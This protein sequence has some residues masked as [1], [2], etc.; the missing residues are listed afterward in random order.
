MKHVS[1]GTSNYINIYN[2]LQM[3]KKNSQLKDE[4]NQT[5]VSFQKTFYESQTIHFETLKSFEFKIDQQKGP[6]DSMLGPEVN[7]RKLN[8]NDS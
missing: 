8:K 2:G 1:G 3:F 6:F 4:G 5:D 7:E